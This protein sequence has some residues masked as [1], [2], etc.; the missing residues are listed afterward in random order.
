VVES[1]GASQLIDTF[2]DSG[3][4]DRFV[5]RLLSSDG[6]WRLVDEVA[7]S[8][9]V[10]AAVSQQGL[11]FADQVGDAV[12]VR[13]RK[14]DRRIERA[15]DRLRRRHAAESPQVPTDLDGPTS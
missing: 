13:S 11:G 9:S 1:D 10:R 2:F 3:L 12:R 5:A 15:A 8:P 6:L 7:A 4:F 14:G